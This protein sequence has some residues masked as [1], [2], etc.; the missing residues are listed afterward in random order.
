M[1]TPT[2]FLIAEV[3]QAHN[4]SF[5]NAIAYI[6]AIANTGAHAIKFQTH[7]AQAESSI[8]EPFRI[9]LQTA[10]KTR[11]DYWK[12]MEFSLEQ[13]IEL[14]KYAE[15]KGLEFLSSPF[16][17]AAVDLLEKIGVK[18]YKVGSGEVSNFLLLQKIAQTKKPLILSSGMSSYAELDK[19]VN[20]LKKLNVDFSILQCST[21]YPTNP[22]NYGLNV[23]AELKQRYGVQVGYSDHSAKIETGIAAVALGAEILEFH[24]KLDSNEIN[25]DASSSI[26]I[27][28]TKELVSG[29]KTISEALKQPVDKNDLTSFQSVKAIFE[30]SLAVNKSMKAGE[31]ILFENL[32]AKKPKGYGID[33]SR[34]NEI[35]GKPLLND[36]KPWDFITTDDVQL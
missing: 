11:Y 4:G 5:E 8:Y 17:N 36:K 33:A 14:K 7:I 27:D 23:I 28:E 30:K 34:F 25:P 16:S 13:W 18:R 9:K 22:E 31:K 10:D 29:V 12:R 3:A 2:P 24:V 21:S 26:T 20:F 19:T 32:E 15:S 1:K 6:D 35:L